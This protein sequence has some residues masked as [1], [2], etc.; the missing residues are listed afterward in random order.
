M[1]G[2][3]AS[4]F[5]GLWM[6]FILIFSLS[7]SI[8]SQSDSLNNGADDPRWYFSF[9][10]SA[11]SDYISGKPT[12]VPVFDSIHKF[13]AGYYKAHHYQTF[14]LFTF[15]YAIRYNLFRINDDHSLSLDMPVA[16]GLNSVLCDDGTRGFLSLSVPLM[17]EFN[18]GAAS[19]FSTLKWKGWMIG[20]GA[21]FNMFPL[22][23]K[24]KYS[25]SDAALNIH[26][27]TADHKWV[28]PAIEVAY[29]W[30]NTDQNTR[31]INLKAGYGAPVKVAEVDKNSTYQPFSI[32][33][34]YLF[35]INY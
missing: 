25:Y 19:N 33:L 35:F 12:N 23:S 21:E 22:I 20:V 34:T 24:E 26:T 16:L 5:R 14:N 15:T 6:T 31:E 4:F 2:E 13:E 29:R 27:V 1:T 11:Y 28:Q 7:N 17:L 32:K 9:G 30:I 18:A 10:V 8:Y 3:R